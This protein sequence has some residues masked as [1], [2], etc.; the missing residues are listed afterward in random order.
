MN[1]NT[2]NNNQVLM[3]HRK[4]CQMADGAFGSF[5]QHLGKAF[6]VADSRNREAL[7]KAFPAF[8]GQE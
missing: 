5:A 1:T 8:W 4:A 6:L 7:I 3:N 2:N